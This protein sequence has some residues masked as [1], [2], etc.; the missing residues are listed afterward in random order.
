MMRTLLLPATAMRPCTWNRC[1]GCDGWDWV[2][3]G[4]DWVRP[5]GDSVRPGW[6]WVRPSWDGFKPWSCGRHGAHAVAA[7]NDTGLWTRARL[8]P[9]IR[10]SERLNI[11][12]WPG[13]S[14]QTTAI[15]IAR[16]LG[17]S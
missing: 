16:F 2:R 6:D 10:R 4:W 5:G 3:P 12:S 17:I 8:G 9:W 1:G 7:D 13:W 15:H 11:A 14:V